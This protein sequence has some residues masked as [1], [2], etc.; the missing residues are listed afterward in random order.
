[1]PSEGQAALE[2]PV[3]MGNKILFVD[4][5]SNI[6]DAYKR[7]LKKQFLIETA[8]SAE[9]GLNAITN[10]GPYAVVVSDLRMPGMDGN[11]FLTRVKEV[12]PRSVRMMLT[13]YADFKTAMEAI[14]SGNIYRL[15]TKPCA[16]NILTEALN[17]GV[18]QYNKNNAAA[19]T[20]RQ[21]E[22]RPKKKVLIVDDD[23][24]MLRIITN[25]LKGFK[26][27]TV[28]TAIHGKEAINLL[29][30]E[31]I[32]MVVTDLYM[33]VL[34]GLQ[35]LS[36]MNKCHPGLP[37]IVLTGHGS[38]DIEARVKALGEFQFFEKPLDM[39]VLSETLIK[40][41]YLHPAGQIHGISTASFLQLI[42]IEER[43]CT[44]K[45]KSG[46]KF[47]RLFFMRGELVAAEHG[48][49]KGEKAAFEII[50]W[51]NSVIEIENVCTKNKKE[52]NKP[53]M[54]LL[55]ESARIKDENS[56]K[57]D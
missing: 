17:A 20:G 51:D 13:G 22:A 42:D 48:N 45:I 19:Q 43:I 54:H 6:L 31:E 29:D 9:E 50:S 38:K 1:L 32:D 37:A 52:I 12:A 25:A 44:L 30:K 35:L 26:E 2:R 28:I 33:P 15:L 21:V 49:T 55:M 53:L 36:Y 34:N 40:T 16:K 7:Q 41:L 47:G 8:L 5:E 3:P 18:E 56:V 10:H 11:Q 14:N 24:V 27:L 57:R 39:N 46:N 4:D 23:R